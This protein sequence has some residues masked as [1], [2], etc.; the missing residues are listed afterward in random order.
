[1]NV[2][3]NYQF[4][5]FYI[6]DTFKFN[7]FIRDYRPASANGIYTIPNGATLKVWLPGKQNKTVEVTDC[8]LISYGA[9]GYTVK[10][11]GVKS[12]QLAEAI[13]PKIT[14][15]LSVNGEETTIEATT[16]LAFKARSLPTPTT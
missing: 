4:D 9:G 5:T 12:A 16:S 10:V 15:I 6:G 11:S 14:C 2:D 1:M 7:V 3:L 13:N 8:T